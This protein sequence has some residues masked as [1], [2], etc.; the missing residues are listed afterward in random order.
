MSKEV[1]AEMVDEWLSAKPT[2]NI[3]T[4]ARSSGVG[5]ST[6][7]RIQTG[8]GKPSLDVIIS[9]G[10]ATGARDKMMEA[11]ETYYP[12]CAPVMMKSSM[13]VGSQ[14][15]ADTT[16]FFETGLSTKLILSLFSREGLS[17]KSI[18]MTH[19]KKG[20]EILDRLLELGIA[21]PEGER[22]VSTEKWYSYRSPDEVLRV[23]RNLTSEFEKTDLGS[24]FARIGV[25][26]ESVNAAGA[27]RIQNVVDDAIAKIRNI[28]DD[29]STLG[30]NVVTVSLLMQRIH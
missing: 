8:T 24:D 22:L 19:G 3:G 13:A 5:E 27:A 14:P 30:D 21:Q 28:M 11:I 16:E 12:N 15:E 7:R 29:S 25:L 26:S 10:R 23:I 4:L 2:R 17:K 20:V 9:I 18:E 6:L 1:L